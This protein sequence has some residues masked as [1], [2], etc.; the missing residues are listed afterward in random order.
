MGSQIGPFS[1]PSIC[2]IVD[3][4]LP[5]SSDGNASQTWS[6]FV[7]AGGLTL[8]ESTME[9]KVET[10]EDLDE[11]LGEL[12]ALGLIQPWPSREQRFRAVGID[13]SRDN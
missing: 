9:A 3:T 10:L 12:M 8:K 7:I 6:P 2:V 5:I 1:N 11:T 13:S 4:R